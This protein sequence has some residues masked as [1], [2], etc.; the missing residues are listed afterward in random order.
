MNSPIVTTMKTTI[1][2]ISDTALWVATYRA[3]E[4]KRSDALFV[5]PFA[6]RLAGEKG[7]AIAKKQHGGMKLTDWTVVMRT[8]I[9]DNIILELIQTKKIDAV[10]NL[11]C[12]LDSRPYRMNLPS[13]FHWIEV[14]FP[15]IIEHKEAVL[16]NE[17]PKCILKKVKL[18]LS[19]LTERKKFLDEMTKIHKN[20]LVLTE[21]VIPYLKNE[22]VKNLGLELCHHP[23][24]KFWLAEYLSPLALQFLLREKTKKIMKNSPF[25]FNPPSWFEFFKESGWK[26]ERT[27]YFSEVGATLNRK[28]KLALWMKI[29]GM[30]APKERLEQF[31]KMSGYTLFV[32]MK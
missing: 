24:I 10:L 26:E 7:F 4:S 21:G 20:I 13:D 18:D 28:P 5:D 3:I 29:L 12:G 16:A 30:L 19:D 22:D 17:I 9:I 15:K 8:Y 31:K 32:P 1:N 27:L 2:D 14:D 6:E 25:Q 11:G 23:E